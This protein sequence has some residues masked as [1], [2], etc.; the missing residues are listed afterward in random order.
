M[1]YIIGDICGNKEKYEKMLEK[2][3][4]KDTDAVFVIGNVLCGENGIEILQDMMYRANIFPVLGKQEYYAKKLL[5]LIA[6]NGSTEKAAENISAEEKALLAEW[7][8]LKCEKTVSD[9]LSL[10][11]EGREAILD[12]LSEFAPYEEIEEGGKT[13]VIASSGI[14]NFDEDKP[15]EDYDEEDFIFA[16]TDYMTPYFSDRYLVTGSKPTAMISREFTG[17]VYSKKRHLAIDCG[18]LYGGN[19]AAVCLNPLKVYYA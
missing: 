5:P 14:R 7:T 11:E 8:K 1:T 4:P 12:Y 17:K 19:L 18:A 3:N 9:F 16:E 2:L 6:E 15:L 13:F 10:D